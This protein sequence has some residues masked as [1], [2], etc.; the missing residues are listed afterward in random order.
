[1]ERSI[2]EKNSMN[3]LK[4]NSMKRSLIL[5]VSVLSVLTI[6][7]QEYK[8]AKATGKLDIREVN[9]VKIEGYGGSEIIFI[10]KDYRGDKDDRAA[11]LRA[12]SNLGLEDNTGIGL[13]VVETNGVIEVRQLKK[14]DGPDI[15]IRVPKGISVNYSHTSPHGSDVSIKNVE[16]DIDVST[17]HNDVM[18][19]NVT[20]IVRVR[21]VHGD[22]DAIFPAEVKNQLSLNSTH[23]HVDVALPVTTKASLKM[24]TSWGE[25][26]VD[27]SLKL[28]L[29][30]TGDFVKYSDRLNA[31]MNGGGTE[32]NLT[33]THDNVYLRKK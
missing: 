30:K 13:S 24:S 15:L 29:D 18:L 25:I 14:M 7:A 27:P 12:I 17:V 21:T 11:G 33:S 22:I 16:S 1:M 32:I 23:G 19:E 5:F 9:E 6:R 3:Y 8:L 26:F 2:S 28:E 31:K 20:G 4:K 10:S